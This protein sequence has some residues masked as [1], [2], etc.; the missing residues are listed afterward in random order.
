MTAVKAMNNYSDDERRYRI[1]KLKE[2]VDA[3]QLLE[4]LGF[5]IYR[6]TPKEIRAACK[7]HGGD[8]KTAFRMNKD[9]KNWV[10]FSHHCHED[11]GYDVISLVMY[12]LNLNFV[13]AVNYLENIT[14][15]NINDSNLFAKYKDEVDKKEFIKEIFNNQYMPP[16]L[17]SEEYLESFKKFRTN[18]FEKPEN[19]GF[20]KEVLDYFEIG[21]GYVDKFG[22]QRE[23]IPIRDDNGRLV[24]Y[25]CRDIT[26]QA[27]DECKYILTENFKKNEVLYN[28]HNAKLYLGDNRELIVVEGF[29][30][31]WKLFMAGYRNVVAC[32]GSKI[33]D[34]QQKLIYKYAK[35]LYTLF[36]ADKAGIKGTVDALSDMKDKIIIKPIFLPY[37]GKD[38]A[39]LSIK[40]LKSLLGGIING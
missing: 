4:S 12:M 6:E 40:Q 31:V 39:D 1:A 22:L 32:M 13:E 5:V 3:R 16:S 27:E 21:G 8:N 29:K 14:G 20:P 28:L 36:D 9:T 10:C 19:G 15:L 30:S 38:P 7:V 33:T 25:S 35:C 2:A 34:G 17:V 24:A 11:I 18:F 23:V 37:T 26:G